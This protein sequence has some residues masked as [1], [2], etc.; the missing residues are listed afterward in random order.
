MS[1]SVRERLGMMTGAEL[2][3]PSAA[4]GASRVPEQL[5]AAGWREIAPYVYVRDGDAAVPARVAGG[6]AAC[7]LLPADCRT[8]DCLFWD[9][10]TTGLAG[11]GT[12]IF[13]V[14]CAWVEGPRVRF[15]QVFL[16]DFPGEQRFLEHLR[17]LFARFRVFVSYNG[18]AF[19]SNILKTR[20]VMSGVTMALGYQLDLLYLAR[21]FWRRLLDN[22]Q[23][24]TIE[25]EV[26]GVRRGD[27]IPGWMAPEIYFDSLRRGVLGQLPAVFR[28]NEADVLALVRLLAV[29]NGVLAGDADREPPVGVDRGAVGSFLLQHGDRRG[30]RVLR[31]AYRA[32]DE[33]AG[34]LLGQHFKRA[35]NWRSAVPLWR[36][37]ARGHGSLRAA[38]ELSKYYEHRARDL[39]AALGA[40]A[41]FLPPMPSI[42]GTADAGTTRASPLGA[43][44]ADAAGGG[45]GVAGATGGPADDGGH[46]LHREARIRAKLRRAAAT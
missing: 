42:G 18:K 24:T 33:H 34:H 39:E 2:L 14:G 17:D 19:D 22:C 43:R 23:L 1:A 36:D 3:V 21:R 44:T 26:L 5:H 28:H 13:L 16:A 11:A 35:G 40:I 38:V 32:G 10:E 41:P 7:R 4:A 6:E 29:V 31:Q 37:M 8:G 9:T 30:A 27:D 46:L 12:V 25:Q 45:A 20:L 15:H